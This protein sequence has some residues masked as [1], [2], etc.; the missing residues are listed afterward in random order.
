MPAKRRAALLWCSAMRRLAGSDS[1]VVDLII[2]P[3]KQA[4]S[5]QASAIGTALAQVMRACGPSRPDIAE[6]I[7]HEIALTGLQSPATAF[8]AALGG[9]SRPPAWAVGASA[10]QVRPPGSEVLGPKRHYQQR[11]GGSS[12][13]MCDSRDA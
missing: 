7:Q 4:I 1:C 12:P 9:R 3:A 11:L 5:N 2:E 6:L 8:Q 10:I 13:V